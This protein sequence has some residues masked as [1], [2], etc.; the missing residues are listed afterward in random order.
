MD[1]IKDGTMSR[2]ADAVACKTA[3]ANLA[4]P[5]A[6]TQND[7]DGPAGTVEAEP[8]QIGDVRVDNEV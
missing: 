4:Y 2:S 1:Y 6:V 8:A 7:E 3:T 5:T